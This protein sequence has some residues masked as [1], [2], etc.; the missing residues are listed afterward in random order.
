[1]LD[2]SPDH[3]SIIQ[4]VLKALVSAAKGRAVVAP[5][6]GSNPSLA[7]GRSKA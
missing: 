7:I 1:M 3:P 2:L 4:T 5:G 6:Y